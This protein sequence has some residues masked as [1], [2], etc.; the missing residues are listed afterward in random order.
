MYATTLP[1]EDKNLLQ[2]K[3]CQKPR[4]NLFVVLAGRKGGRMQSKNGGHRAADKRQF[5]KILK[6]I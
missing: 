1:K 3:S 2:V 4:N 5:Y 6:E